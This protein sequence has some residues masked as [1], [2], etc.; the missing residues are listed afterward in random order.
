[1]SIEE[2]KAIVRRYYD[3]AP[4]NLAACDEIFAPCFDFHAIVHTNLTSQT[5]QSSPAD[6]KAFIEQYKTIWGGWNF[7]IEEM[8]AEGD[9]VMVRWSSHGTHLHA[10]NGLPPTN[11]EVANSGINIFRIADGKI[12]EVWDIYDR[13]WVWQQ[14]GVLPDVKDAITQA[15]IK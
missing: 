13:L 1:M 6:E 5:G 11:R 2:N 9:R 3:D 7:K 15:V 12:A 14:L 10:Y 8:I 4:F